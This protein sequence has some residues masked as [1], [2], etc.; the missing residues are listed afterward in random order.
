MGHAKFADQE[1]E[2]I[3][4][5]KYVQ[6]NDEGRPGWASLWA[7]RLADSI[8]DS[9]I[10]RFLGFAFHEEAIPSDLHDLIAAYMLKRYGSLPPPSSL[11]NQKKWAKVAKLM[12]RGKSTTR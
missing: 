11:S 5:H 8:M 4:C 2:A 3:I 7:I 12:A 1:L 10:R 6:G 9:D